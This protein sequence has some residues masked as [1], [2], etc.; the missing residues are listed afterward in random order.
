MKYDD[1]KSFASGSLDIIRQIEPEGD[2][3]KTSITDEKPTRSPV[4]S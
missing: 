3:E 4:E 2:T 1:E